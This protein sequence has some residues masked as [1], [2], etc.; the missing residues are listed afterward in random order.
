MDGRLS[1]SG[2]EISERSNGGTFSVMSST[3]TSSSIALSK[4][5]FGMII[6]SRFSALDNKCDGSSSAVPQPE[7]GVVTAVTDVADAEGRRLDSGSDGVRS[8]VNELCN[9]TPL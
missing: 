8:S 4:F 1:S 3:M 7:S 9:D 5:S 6:G 2:G